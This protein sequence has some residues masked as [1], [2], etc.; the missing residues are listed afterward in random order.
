MIFRVLPLLLVTLALSSLALA[1]TY[2][3]LSLDEMLAATEVAF[4]GQVADVTV[5]DRDGEPWTVV[6]FEVLEPLLGVEDRLDEDG[7]SL[8]LAFYG[9]TLPSGE[10]VTVSLMPQFAVGELALILA[11]DGDY[12]SPIV[13][14][15]QG[16]WRDSTLGLRDETDRLLGFDEE[17]ELLLD[18][19][20]GDTD[21]I[22]GSLRAALEARP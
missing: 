12:Y 4:Y 9:G 7:V 22:I 20:G 14:F 3:E 6:T 19:V 1:T 15:R 8:A 5:E 18:S 2:R 16:V 10:T 11:Y 13:G 21:T 17:D